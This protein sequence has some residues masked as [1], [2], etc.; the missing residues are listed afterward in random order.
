MTAL[1]GTILCCRGFQVACQIH[2]RSRK[3]LLPEIGGC[4]IELDVSP[5]TKFVRPLCLAPFPEDRR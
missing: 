2:R 5:V 1:R 4:T 3:E